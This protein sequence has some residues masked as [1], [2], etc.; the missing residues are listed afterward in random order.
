MSNGKPALSAALSAF[1]VL[2]IS[3][4]G[5]GT[6]QSAY[7]RKKPGISM[8]EIEARVKNH[9]KDPLAYCDR[10]LAYMDGGE[11][12]L[13]MQDYNTALKLK[14]NFARALLGRASVSM[15]F[16][17]F[18]SAL[19]DVDKALA[20]NDKVLESDILEKKLLI[21]RNLKRLAECPPIYEKLLELRKAGR[22]D[23]TADELY[24]ARAEIYIELKKPELAL[25][26]LD[27][28][29]KVTVRE[30]YQRALAYTQA[31]KMI[32]KPEKALVVCNEALSA[33]EKEPDKIGHTKR[34]K[35]VQALYQQRAEIY[36]KM[37]K[38]DLANKD[39]EKAKKFQLKIYDMI[40]EDIK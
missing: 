39:L 34:D 17:K 5:S 31:C 3:S 20:Q 11:G 24:L 1:V 13:A 8:D 25:K 35:A 10:A 28:I 4:M 37:G 38:Q 33:A 2:M 26:D 29:T 40:Y 27:A 36:K 18:D 6:E 30:R 21:L 7:A 12:E 23:F 32:K 19:S 15:M 9:P 16:E 22:T 14:P